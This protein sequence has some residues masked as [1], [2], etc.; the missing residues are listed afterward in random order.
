MVFIMPLSAF[1]FNFCFRNIFNM[2]QKKGSKSEKIKPQNHTMK[3]KA[4]FV[5][6]GGIGMAALERYCLSKGWKSAVMTG[7]R[8]SLLII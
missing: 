5:G 3:Q 6:A 2:K 8:L 4:Y 7:H 1:I